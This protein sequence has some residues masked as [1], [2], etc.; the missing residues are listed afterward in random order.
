MIYPTL[1]PMHKWVAHRSSPQLKE[2]EQL[3]P[4]PAVPPHLRND[5]PLLVP[6]VSVKRVLSIASQ[7][8]PGGSKKS[9]QEGRDDSGE[10]CPPSLP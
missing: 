9:R 1:T 6:S 7:T 2:E 4:S 8:G 10:V 5:M 3:A